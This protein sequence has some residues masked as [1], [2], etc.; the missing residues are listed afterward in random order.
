MRLVEIRDLDGPNLFMP[1]PAIKL[2]M[3]KEDDETEEDW[4]AKLDPAA[5]SLLAACQN[6]IAARCGELGADLATPTSCAAGPGHGRG[7]RGRPHRS[8][9]QR[10]R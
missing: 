4:A 2:E 6:F 7:G 10:G 5:P 3:I 9:H 8:G 1:L